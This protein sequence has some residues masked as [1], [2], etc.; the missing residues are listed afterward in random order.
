M[1][2]NFGVL[3][4]GLQ[5]DHLRIG[6]KLVIDRESNI[7]VGNIGCGT[8]TTHQ[9]IFTPAL[10][11]DKSFEGIRLHGNLVIQPGS[12]LIG[13]VEMSG[14][15]NG[16]LTVGGTGIFGGNIAVGDSIYTS[17]LRP[18]T[19][20]A[21]ITCT[22]NIKMDRNLTVMESISA[23]SIL[24]DNLISQP[25]SMINILGSLNLID[26]ASSFCGNIVTLSIQAKTAAPVSISGGLDVA[27]GCVTVPKSISTPSAVSGSLTTPGGVLVLE[28][29]ADLMPS[30]TTSIGLI[31]PCILSTSVILCNIGSFTGTGTPIVYRVVPSSGTATV[32]VINVDPVNPIPIGTNIPINFLIV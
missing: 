13:D 19:L 29:A 6:D 18:E 23:D 14:V 32:S 22:G 30:S 5:G 17:T 7:M 3:N 9:G 15:I 28:L 16:D 10:V 21:S 25:S 31:N 1:A 20:G 12:F 4:K 2:A 26:G 27:S 24:V 8:L 11:E